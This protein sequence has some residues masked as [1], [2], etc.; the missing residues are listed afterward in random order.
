MKLFNKNTRLAV[1]AAFCCSTN[2][3]AQLSGPDLRDKILPHPS[4]FEWTHE[5]ELIV[6]LDNAA[7][8][9]QVANLIQDA[10]ILN[11]SLSDGQRIDG[12]EISGHSLYSDNALTDARVSFSNLLAVPGITNAENSDA[13]RM[14]GQIDFLS[15]NYANSESFYSQAFDIEVAE[16]QAGNPHRL[17]FIAPMYSYVTELQGDEQG[18]LNI[19]TSALAHINSSVESVPPYNMAKMLNQASKL[20]L[21]TGDN[22]LS[23]TLVNSIEQD[24]PEFLQQ[25]PKLSIPVQIELRKLNLNGHSIEN[26]DEVSALKAMEILE[27]PDYAEMPLRYSIGESLADQLEKQRKL[28]GIPAA[29]HLRGMLI[30]DANNALPLITDPVH[31]DLILRAKARTVLSE[32]RMQIN[33]NN[34]ATATALLQ[35][36]ETELSADYT[37]FH[38]QIQLYLTAIPTP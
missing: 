8:R 29:S 7:D 12:Y 3:F 22:Q 20:A 17:V 4:E 14:L 6:L 30:A 11:T 33:Q 13:L 9:I 1:I 16:L 24:Y 19:L 26:L 23:L 36:L 27:N 35:D 25:D 31:S 28:G 5:R 15:K 18:A 38:A 2:A 10:C 21:R 34:H 37:E 32:A